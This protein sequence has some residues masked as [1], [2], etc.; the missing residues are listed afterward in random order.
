MLV[1]TRIYNVSFPF[2]SSVFIKM[3]I[4]GPVLAELP[5]AA[6]PLG[7][8]QTAGV[9]TLSKSAFVRQ[10]CSRH[11]QTVL[12]GHTCHREVSPN[13]ACVAGIWSLWDISLTL[14]H[15]TGVGAQV[16]PVTAPAVLTLCC[17]ACVCYVSTQ[18]LESLCL[19]TSQAFFWSDFFFICFASEAQSCVST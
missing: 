5:R 12:K 9:F 7:G 3:S 4:G 8:Q 6:D 15:C 1:I 2:L 10:C 16:Y 17:A 18:L 11:G 14:W 19:P 13:S